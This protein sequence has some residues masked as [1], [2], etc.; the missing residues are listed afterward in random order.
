MLCVTATV[1][2]VTANTKEAE[3]QVLCS[4]SE[5][6]PGES[7]TVSV[8]VNTNFPVA[9]MSIPVFYDKTI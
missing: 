3:I 5:L 9:T 2:V 7:T 1:V 4:D 6:S 8:K